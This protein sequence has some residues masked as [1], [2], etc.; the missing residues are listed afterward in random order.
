LF[1]YYRTAHNIVK[2]F[3]NFHF[4]VFGSLFVNFQTKKLAI[5]NFIKT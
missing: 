2:V 1:I 4:I 5:L 3:T